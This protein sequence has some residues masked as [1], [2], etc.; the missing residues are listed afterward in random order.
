MKAVV[1]KDSYSFDEFC[2]FVKKFNP[3]SVLRAV[4]H[5]ALQL[6][7]NHNDSE[8]WLRFPPWALA[9]IIRVSITYGLPYR[10][11]E[12]DDRA[13]RL[14][15]N[16]Y[17]GIDDNTLNKSDSNLA[18]TILTRFAFEQFPYQESVFEEVARAHA[19][20][21]E[22]SGRQRLTVI[23]EETLSELFGAPL[24]LLFGVAV[25]L[26][27]SA[28]SNDGRFERTWLD[29]P[30]FVE[31]LKILPRA[32]V[33]SVIENVFS[34]TPESFREESLQ[35]FQRQPGR[36][37]FNPLTARPLI[38]TGNKAYVAPVPQLLTRKVSPLEHYYAGLKRWDVAFTKD[39][40][41]LFEDY[42]GRQLAAIPGA[43]VLPEI[44]YGHRTKRAKSVDWIVVL[45]NLIVLVEAKATRVPAPARSEGKAAV[46]AFEKTI[47][48]AI[49]QI[50]RTYKALMSGQAEFGSIPSERDIIGVVATLDSWYWGNTD[51]A[52]PFLPACEIPFLVASSREIESLVTVAQSRRA[53]EILRELIEPKEG[54]W[55]LANSLSKY[56][57]SSAIQNPILS[58]AFANYPF[59][60]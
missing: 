21:L 47:G 33:L 15:C 44:E 25:L 30:N 43:T 3:S 42:I 19:L 48:E 10:T 14:A 45:P 22:Y 28:K 20:F 41:E 50:S 46:T 59:R 1:F 4:T 49:R 24:P 5:V 2:D 34:I 32:A 37:S 53:E 52:R 51:F 54:H 56:E 18:F 9:A 38:A 6:P 31:V 8:I 27:S 35:S 60:T 36:F 58:Q 17:G 12:M 11:K 7:D 57:I 16:I 39:L 13:L 23:N 29:Q 26:A 40:G 55:N